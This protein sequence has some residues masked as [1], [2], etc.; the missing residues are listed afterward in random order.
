MSQEV[1]YYA[2]PYRDTATREKAQQTAIDA[3][4]TTYNASNLSKPVRVRPLYYYDLQNNAV[5]TSL[6]TNNNEITLATASGSPEGFGY[7]ANMTVKVPTDKVFVIYGL[8]DLSAVPV[9]DA[10]KLQIQDKVYPILYL[11]PDIKVDPNASYVY[12]TS[13]RAIPPQ[14][15]FILTFYGSGTG[16]DN[17]DMLGYVAELGTAPG[18]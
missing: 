18:E 1:V 11:S 12:P 15:T 8:A 16:P 2:V 13:F 7:S 14:T 3:A 4:I 10:W 9:L 5:G 17:I 6:Y